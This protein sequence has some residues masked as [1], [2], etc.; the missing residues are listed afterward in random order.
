MVF[1]TDQTIPLHELAPEV[2]ARGFESL[3]VT[4]KT[5]V[6]TSRRTPWPGG[7]LPEWYKRTC[8]PLI[9]LAAAAAVTTRLRLGTGVLLAGVRDPVIAAKEIASLDWLSGGRLELGMGYGWNSEELETHGVRLRDA[10]DVLADHVALMQ[11]LWTAEVASF[12]GRFAA[13]EPCWSWPKPVQQPRPPL[14]LGGR[15]SARLFADVAAYGDGWMPIEGFG[16]ITEHMSTLRRAFEAVG[17][18]PESAVV[19]V[20]SSAG[21]IETMATYAAAG[22][23]RVVVWLPPADTGSVLAALDAHRA[24]LADV[25]ES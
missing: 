12:A 19:T 5:H 18:D 15:A 21:D 9:A 7:E 6:P 8:D 13:V 16:A 10:P 20:Y 1:A 14:H 17:R 22:V 11:E 25:L 24:R 3:W 2:E 23:D 4:E